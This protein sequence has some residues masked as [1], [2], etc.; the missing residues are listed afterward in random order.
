MAL[1][2]RVVHSLKPK[3][4]AYRLFDERGLYLEVAPSGSK[5]WWFK[6]RSAQEVYMTCADKPRLREA[7][8]SAA[9][10]HRGLR[11]HCWVRNGESEPLEQPVPR[12]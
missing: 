4:K 10:D 1:T 11:R 3:Q 2:D 9:P 7:L 6:W 12:I 5:W 8:R